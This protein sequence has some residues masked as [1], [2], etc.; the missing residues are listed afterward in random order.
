MKIDDIKRILVL[1]SG[2]MGHQIGFLCA[3]HGYDVV[4][5][6]INK[7]VLEKA[8]GKIHK[9]ADRFVKKKRLQIDQKEKVIQMISFSDNKKKAALDVDLITE[10]VPEDPKLKA[11]IF[12][13]FNALC[14]ERTIFTTNTSTLIPSMI[15]DATGRPEKFL[16]LHFHDV[17]LSNVVDVM[18][19][20]GTSKE[21]IEIVK[22]FAEKMDQVVITLKKENF[23]YVFNSM[24]SDL[25]KSALTLASNQVATVEDIDRSWMGVMSTPSGPFGLMDAIGLDTIW[26]IMDYWASVSKKEQHKRNAAFVKQYVDSGKLGTKTGEGFYHYP[27]PLFRKSDFIRGK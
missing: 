9:L 15:A 16:A 2:T 3:L 6:D 1:G 24:L 11:K 7:D 13:E 10:S 17:Y 12:N 26:K 21:T 22:G 5:Y 8:K 19:H 25:F 14:P 4:I 18:P 20:P 27:D 23:G